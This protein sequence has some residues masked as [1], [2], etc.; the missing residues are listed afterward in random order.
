MQPSIEDLYMNM[1]RSILLGVAFST[2]LAIACRDTDPVAGVVA[3]PIR[4]AEVVQLITPAVS[5]P[6]GMVVG[7]LGQWDVSGP[8][9]LDSLAM[10]NIGWI[11]LGTAGWYYSEPDSASSDHGFGIDTLYG[12]ISRLK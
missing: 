7:N 2:T 11:R 12:D 4:T 8:A 9:M 3:V 1:R 5:N 10:A 6:F